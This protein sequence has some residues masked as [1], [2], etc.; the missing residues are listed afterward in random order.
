MRYREL[1]SKQ[2]KEV[3]EFPFMFAFTNEQ[4]KEGM[5]ELGLNKDNK[6][7]RKKICSLGSGTFI[8]KS[9]INKMNEMFDRHKEELKALI[10]ED[11]TGDNFIY[12]MFNY[13]LA[14]HEYCISG[15]IDYTLDALGFTIE[16]V[17][18]NSKLKHGLQKAMTK[19]RGW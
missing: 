2:A 5:L 7:D 17:N 9:D 8:K 6:D 10:D 19:Q 12:D 16:D 15:E 11:S 1:K 13:E 14:D 3:H 4:L 18:K